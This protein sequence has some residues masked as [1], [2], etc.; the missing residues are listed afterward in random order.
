MLCIGPWRNGALFRGSRWA[1]F[2]TWSCIAPFLQLIQ[3]CHMVLYCAFAVL[4]NSFKPATGSIKTV[5]IYPSD[6]GLERMVSSRAI[7]CAALSSYLTGKSAGQLH[8]R[9]QIHV[10]LDT[11]PLAS[12]A[13][14]T[15]SPHCVCSG[16]ALLDARRTPD[17]PDT[18]CACC[19]TVLHC[20]GAGTGRRRHERSCCFPAQ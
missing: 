2:A 19:G 6:F 10:Q 13:C 16:A 18:S 20:M 12:T 11:A 17:T 1:S 3:A 7:V 9:M 5:T 8:G 14:P 15:P 4:A